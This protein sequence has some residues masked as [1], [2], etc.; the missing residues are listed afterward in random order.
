M[1]SLLGSSMPVHSHIHS[2]SHSHPHS[3]SQSRPLS[4]G[5]AGQMATGA[6]RTVRPQRS[7]GNFYNETQSESPGR[8]GHVRS[9]SHSPLIQQHTYDASL[10]T[11]PYSNGLSPVG[12]GTPS[13]FPTTY[14]LVGSETSPSSVALPLNNHNHSHHQCDHN[15]HGH[16]DHDHNLDHNH[17]HHFH[18]HSEPTHS[19]PEKRS[20]FTNMLL[21]QTQEWGLLQSILKEKDS[22]RIFY[23]MT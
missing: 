11:P 8:R 9:H 19:I 15:H 1:A 3:Y 14:S 12:G 21:Y 22:R 7:D 13:M 23:F 16:H 17:P 6:S 4:L 20:M 5:P 10:P 18:P 2:H